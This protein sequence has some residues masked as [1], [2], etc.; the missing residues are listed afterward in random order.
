MQPESAVWVDM[1]PTALSENTSVKSAWD[2]YR[3]MLHMTENIDTEA[4]E[5]FK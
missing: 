4:M 5:T 1:F 2:N 3:F